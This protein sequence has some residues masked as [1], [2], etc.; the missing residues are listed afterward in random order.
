V[1]AALALPI[2][3]ACS[4]GDGRTPIPSPASAPPGAPPAI[5]SHTP[6]PSPLPD[7]AA[8][9]NGQAIGIRAVRLLVEQAPKPPTAEEK[10]ATYRRALQQ[11]IMRE[12][13]FQ[14]A[15]KRR[16]TADEARLEQAYNEARVQFKD[17]AAWAAMLAEKGVDPQFFRTELRVQHTVQAL[18]E[19]V[20]REAAPA[21]DDEARAF[22]DSNAASLTEG[23]KVR[24]AHILVR[25]P[26]GTVGPAK[27]ALRAKAEALRARLRK[28]ED[29]AT[30]ARTASED[31]DS[32]AR[33]GDLGELRKGQVAE[34]FEQ[35][36]FTLSPGK[37]SGL[38][39][40][41]YGFHIIKVLERIPSRRLA[42]EEVRDRIKQELTL[43]KQLERQRSFVND[44]R[45]RA[46]IETFL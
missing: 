43:R 33:G 20:G 19:Q 42:F 37:V 39:E 23:E 4:G 25:V 21:S 38:V 31:A 18:L 41:A 9:V 36:A 15:M 7:V 35:A 14:E 17:D 40:T 26:P 12:L 11:L 10:P 2:L 5:D 46:R 45:T 6:L 16:L 30:L 13:L 1:L 27:D 22:F 29:F 24:A 34:P 8:R 32:A 3:G 44:L 28:G